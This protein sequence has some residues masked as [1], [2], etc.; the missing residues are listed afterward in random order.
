RHGWCPVNWAELWD[1]RELLFFL[2]WRDIKVRYKQTLLGFAWAVLGPLAQAIIFTFIFARVAALPSDGLPPA[3][4][5]MAGLVV[6]GYFATSLAMCANSLVGN[7]PLL[8]K[9]YLPRLIIPLSAVVTGLVDLLIAFG[10]LLV[11]MLYYQIAPAAT[12]LLL[13]LLVLMAMGAALGTGLIFAALNVKYRDVRS[14]APFLVQL[15]MYCTLIVPFSQM[16]ERF[17]LWRYLYGLNPMAGVVEGFRWCLAHH[18][19]DPAAAPPWALL[20]VGAPV[21]V[22]LVVCGLAYF[23]RVES[24]FADIV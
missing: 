11:M 20:A 12:V 18:L 8:T 10:I 21:T 2:A 1:A 15:L 23:K 9:I 7:Q 13:P 6:W 5:Y 17:G 22:L 3:V 24:Q 19:M 16:P 14:I 4:F